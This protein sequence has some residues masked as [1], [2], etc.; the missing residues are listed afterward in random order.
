M[1]V[2]LRS[3]LLLFLAIEKQTSQRV[4]LEDEMLSV[5]SESVVEL[6]LLGVEYERKQEVMYAKL[7][8]DHKKSLEKGKIF[9]NSKI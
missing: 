1:I 8:D 3:Q 6:A 7:M 5:K 4:R 9:K 2:V